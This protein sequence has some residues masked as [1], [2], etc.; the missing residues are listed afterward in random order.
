MMESQKQGGRFDPGI[1]TATIPFFRYGDALAV[2]IRHLALHKNNLDY[3]A[4]RFIPPRV[5]ARAQ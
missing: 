1:D 5:A 4:L 2:V 3:V